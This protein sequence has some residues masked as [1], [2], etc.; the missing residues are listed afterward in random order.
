[1]KMI[2]K[3]FLAILAFGAC[4]VAMGTLAGLLIDA[5]SGNRRDL[6]AAAAVVLFGLLAGQCWILH[7][8]VVQYR[9]R[10]GAAQG[11][12]FIAPI[13]VNTAGSERAVRESYMPER[14]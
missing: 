5:A 7:L 3:C 4:L 2:C 10:R 1:M 12:Q 14:P 6:G 8:L 9:P 13:A 11:L